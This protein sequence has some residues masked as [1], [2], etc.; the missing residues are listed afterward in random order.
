MYAL[1]KIVN[2]FSAF[3]FRIHSGII[4]VHTVVPINTIQKMPDIHTTGGKTLHDPKTSLQ[5]LV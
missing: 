2:P 5:N 4:I 3:S 1:T